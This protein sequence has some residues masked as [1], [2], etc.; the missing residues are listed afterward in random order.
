MHKTTEI[1]VCGTRSSRNCSFKSVFPVEWLSREH[2]SDFLR[3]GARGPRRLGPTASC[4]PGNTGT[5]RLMPRSGVAKHQVEG[6][7]ES[8]ERCSRRHPRAELTDGGGGG[9]YHGEDRGGALGNIEGPKPGS[10]WWVLEGDGG[11]RWKGLNT[12]S[13]VTGCLLRG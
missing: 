1:Q 6:P 13:E 2:L 5:E 11:R 12:G 7:W 4:V 10:P 8:L 9:G 3:V